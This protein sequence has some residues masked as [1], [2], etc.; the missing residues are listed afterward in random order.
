MI[1]IYKSDYTEEQAKAVA[2]LMM[3]C[4]ASV[5]MQY[6]ASGSGTQMTPAVSALRNNFLLMQD[7]LCIP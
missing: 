1:P 3:V 4:G 5:D 2:E 6:T 7:F